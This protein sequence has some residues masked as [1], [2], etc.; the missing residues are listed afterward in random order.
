MVPP[1][2]LLP[3]ISVRMVNHT[4]PL[5]KY[6]CLCCWQ[7]ESCSG[8][9]VLIMQCLNNVFYFPTVCAR[10]KQETW[11]QLEYPCPVKLK[12]L[13]NSDS[14]CV[15]TVWN[16][17]HQSVVCITFAVCCTASLLPSQFGDRQVWHSRL[18]DH[19]GGPQGGSS[20]WAARFHSAG[21]CHHGGRLRGRCFQRKFLWTWEQLAGRTRGFQLVLIHLPQG[22]LLLLS[23]NIFY[24]R[25]YVDNQGPSLTWTNFLLL[26][27][28]N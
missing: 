21:R 7:F 16:Q 13:Y 22:Y 12:S 11:R 24:H 26:M 1:L 10:A 28:I 2:Q 4:L 18:G 23:I 6:S 17:W 8:D 25:L 27:L 20:G 9:V 3:C 15:H 14:F 19:G 5:W